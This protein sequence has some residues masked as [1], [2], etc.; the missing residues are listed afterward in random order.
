[1]LGSKRLLKVLCVH[2]FLFL[3]LACFQPLTAGPGQ[4]GPSLSAGYPLETLHEILLP[5]SEWHPFATRAQ[6]DFWDSLPEDTRRA[7]ID[8]AEQALNSFR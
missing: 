7:H 8:R 4:T 6:R 3:L 5:R 1:M 2:A